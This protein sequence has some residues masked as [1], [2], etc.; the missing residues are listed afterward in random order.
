ELAT[1]QWEIELREKDKTLKE[2]VPELAP[3]ETEKHRKAAQ[4]RQ[5]ELAGKAEGVRKALE[6][7]GKR[8]A[9]ADNDVVEAKAALAQASARADR[10]QKRRE[11]E[12]SFEA[13]APDR[14]RE[15]LAGLVEEG[16]GLKG[17]FRLSL[18]RVEEQQEALARSVARL[19]ALKPP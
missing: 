17:A 19:E 1:F 6:Q 15:E 10:E 3:A 14:L 16:P 12:K 2:G 18:Q 11:M 13:L 9:R 7:V 4:A 5:A 8:L